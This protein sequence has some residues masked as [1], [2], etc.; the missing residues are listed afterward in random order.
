MLFFVT[1]G[2]CLFGT[3][4]WFA[5]N[6]EWH[7]PGNPELKKIGINNETCALGNL[8]GCR[9]A[10][11]RNSHWVPGVVVWEETPFPS[12]IHA[13]WFV[14]VTITTV[15]Y[16]DAYP[17]TPYGKLFGSL[18]ILCGIVVLAMPVGVIGANFSNEY[19]KIQADKRRREKLKELRVKKAEEKKRVANCPPLPASDQ[20]ESGGGLP[21]L[22]DNDEDY[23]DL[24]NELQ[25][26]EGLVDLAEALDS[27]V[28]QLIPAEIAGEASKR[29]RSDL[30]EFL[31]VLVAG[32]EKAAM[33][34]PTVFLDQLSYRVFTEIRA[35]AQADEQAMENI[36][37]FR[38]KWAQF[39]DRCWGYWI[40]FPPK[41]QEPDDI[42][43]LKARLSRLPVVQLAG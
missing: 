39:V 9:G 14:I 5:E 1:L 42:F 31:Q 30:A 24:A 37:E 21:D 26:V 41:Q 40:E 10:F 23:R 38:R 2:L 13:F 43:E 15:G 20:S 34:D 19:D 8:T 36:I 12:I 11:L 22:G 27:D 28:D 18:M 17:T 7:P 25:H 4:I 33:S 29:C 16:G 35:V 6:G 3:L 32:R